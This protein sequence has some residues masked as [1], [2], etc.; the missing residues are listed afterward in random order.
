MSIN[1]EAVNKDEVEE[2]QV[3]A[4]EMMRFIGQKD[5]AEKEEET[6]TFCSRLCHDFAITKDA[7]KSPAFYRFQLYY[8]L[9]GLLCPSFT[10]YAYQ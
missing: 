1:L 5:E 7:F 4:D 9:N 6:E 8:L 3:G 2:N 10:T